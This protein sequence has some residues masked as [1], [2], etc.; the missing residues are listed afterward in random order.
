MAIQNLILV[1][2]NL[3]ATNVA[4]QGRDAGVETLGL[5]MPEA[6]S[7]GRPTSPGFTRFEA[8]P[9]GT[10]N[11]LAT[12]RRLAKRF[13]ITA[14]NLPG[15][16]VRSRLWQLP[17]TWAT[18]SGSGR[19]AGATVVSGRAGSERHPWHHQTSG[20]DYPSHDRRDDQNGAE[21]FG[22]ALRTNHGK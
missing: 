16:S 15:L 19:S 20:H 2:K 17:E 6:L 13:A 5:R 18:T 10:P 12:D 4:K 8:Y 3:C 22:S 1:F 14:V 21:L 7:Q 9:H 11:V